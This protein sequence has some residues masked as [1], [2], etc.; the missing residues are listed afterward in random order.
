[1]NRYLVE[2]PDGNLA[3]AASG[4]QAHHFSGMGEPARLMFAVDPMAI[5]RDVK[6]APATCDEGG[7]HLH[8]LFQFRR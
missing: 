8:R 5:H 6:D 2:A 7:V 1:M 3:S 4:E